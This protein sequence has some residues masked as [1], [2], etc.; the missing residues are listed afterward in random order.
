LNEQLEVLKD[1]T[2]RLE[3]AR[4]AY[5]VSG[6]TALNYYAQPRLT[7]DIDIVLELE[8]ADVA[9]LTNLFSDRYYLDE[10]S[11]RDAIARPGMFNIIHLGYIVKVD[12]IVRKE[13]EYR[14][15]EFAR[16]HRVEAAG[17]SFSI[18]SPEDLLLSKLD[19]ARESLSELQLS[20][21]RNLIASVS[22]LDWEY[23]CRWA[24][25]LGVAELLEEVR[26]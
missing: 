25:S 23:L 14:H 3:A 11:I 7:R 19:W 18:V 21:V 1:V 9:R 22:G 20:D 5:M 13:S 10:E 17:V 16:R 8:A 15:V 6:S 24:A 26:L 2:L 12:C 4:I